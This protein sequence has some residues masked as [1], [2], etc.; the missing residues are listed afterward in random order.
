MANPARPRWPDGPGHSGAT[1][2]ARRSPPAPDPDRA[3]P[4]AAG[5]DLAPRLLAQL[6]AARRLQVGA[7]EELQQLLRTGAERTGAAGQLDALVAEGVAG[8]LPPLADLADHAVVG[9]EDA[10]E[11]DLVEHRLA[12]QLAQRAY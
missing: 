1:A 6:R 3:R 9:D 11:E 10:V 5:L 12:G 7:L 2:N 4:Q 8:D